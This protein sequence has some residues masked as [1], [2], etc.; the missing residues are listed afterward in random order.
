MTFNSQAIKAYLKKGEIKKLFIEGLGWDTGQA[1]KDCEVEGTVYSLTVVASKAGFKVWH[2]ELPGQRLPSRDEMKTVH[3]Q[4]VK[5]SYE[6]IIIFSSKDKKSQG[7]LWV[8]REANKPISYK[9]HLFNISQDGESL[10]QKL[11]AL[12]ITFEEEE[13]GVNIVDVTKRAKAAFDVEKVTKKFYQE[14][15]KHRKV[16]LGFIDGIPVEADREWYASVMLNR[17]MFAY[18]IQKK[19]FLDSNP[20]YLKTKLKEC[21]A[22][23]GEDKFYSFYR[24]FLLRLFHEG[25]GMKKLNRPKGLEALLGNIPYLNGGMFD[26]HE[27]EHPDRYGKTIEIKDQAFEK[28]FAYFDQYQWHLDERPLRSDKE[29]NPDVLGYIF[30]KYINQKQMGAYYTKED[31]TEYI[32][33]STI[34]PCIFDA[35]QKQYPRPFDLADSPIWALLKNNP[36]E[37]IYK[38]LRHGIEHELPPEVITEIDSASPR[39]S[40]ARSCW[41]RPASPELGLPTETWREVIGRRKRY[42]A[43]KS[44]LLSGEVRKIDELI[45]LNLDVR[46]FALEVIDSCEDPGLIWAIWKSVSKISILDPTGGSGA[47]LFAALNILEPIYEGCLERMASFE[48]AE[49]SH[50]NRDNFRVVL[51]GVS[52]HSN[53]KYYI[54]KSIILNNL[55]AVDIMEEAVEI[56]KLRLFL[57]LAAQ[58]EP[59]ALLEN[60][61]IEPLP[62]IDFNIRSGNT[63]IGYSSLDEVK[64]AIGSGFDFNNTMERLARKAKEHQDA[65]DRYRNVQ[66]ESSGALIFADKVEMLNRLKDLESELNLHLAGEYGI[67][68][69]DNK[70]YSEWVKTHQPFHWFVEF[71]GILNSGGFDVIL[72][73]P[74]YVENSEVRKL[75]SIQESVFKTANCGNLYAPVMERSKALLRS[76]GRLGMIVPISLV[77]IDDFSE[78][79]RLFFTKE[80]SAHLLNFGV[81]PSKLFEGVA[82]RLSIL[83]WARSSELKP[84]RTT[85]YRRWYESERPFLLQL[86]RFAPISNYIEGNI[87]PKIGPEGVLLIDKMNS[88]TQRLGALIRTSSSHSLLYHRSPNN[89]IRAH[90]KVPYY[91]GAGGETISKDHIRVLFC[92]SREDRDLLVAIIMSSLFFWYWETFG[93]CRNLTET[94]IHRFPFSPNAEIQNSLTSIVSVLMDDMGVHSKRKVRKQ[95]LTGDVEYDEFYVRESKNIIDDIDVALSSHYG[96]TPE[97]LDFVINYDIKYRLGRAEEDEA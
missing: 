17:L 75:Y 43:L 19:G 40:S 63:L 78:L 60:F 32:S 23:K 61:G 80:S 22:K 3:R 85:S 14:F 26:V 35:A 4:L 94:D 76:T 62:D 41:N 89:F 42:L 77:A 87:V 34:I 11:R 69:G 31:I 72:G 6:H 65:F 36:D 90:T 91:R 53:R 44:L 29:I 15:D 13:S 12:Y 67:I 71:H 52:S 81:F 47:F 56:C 9:H 30:E 49:L 84:L 79:R 59:S 24:I 51:E 33:K 95:K 1:A 45:S 82:Q 74:P 64:R 83:I 66:S 38:A 55:Y 7:W 21:Q 8:R 86:T 92:E 68:A 39:L 46:Q 97:E 50:E 54:L 25:L 27:L 10:A 57:K 88:V 16:F 93:N 18:F 2:C 48:M 58:V 20:D 96:F 70:R 73:N 28:V 5:E 37:F